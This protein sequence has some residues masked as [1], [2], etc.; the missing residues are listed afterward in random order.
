MKQCIHFSRLVWLTS[1]R[2]NGNTRVGIA[3]LESDLAGFV[4]A[5]RANSR[6][7]RNDRLR[8]LVDFSHNKCF[9]WLFC[10]TVIDRRCTRTIYSWR[11]PFGLYRTEWTK[12]LALLESNVNCRA[13]VNL[14]LCRFV[15]YLCNL[16][17]QNHGEEV[18]C[19]YLIYGS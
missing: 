9:Y 13:S 3:T 12:C 8:K 14:I 5:V 18:L 7:W 2:H 19:F 16:F 6:R 4:Q 1:W 10:S 17:I 15:S 11:E